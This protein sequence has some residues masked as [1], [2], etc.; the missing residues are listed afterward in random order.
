MAGKIPVI[1]RYALGIWWTRWFLWDYYS[2]RQVIETQEKNQLPVDVCILDMNWHIK[3]AWGAYS[4]DTNVFPFSN[5]TLDWLQAKNLRVAMNLHDDNG[6]QKYE[7]KFDDMCKAMGLNPDTTSQ[8]QF[9][10]CG[11][12]TYAFSLEDVVLKPLEDQ[13]INFWWID[14]QQDPTEGGCQNDDLNPTM[15]L[16][17]LRSTDSKRRAVAKS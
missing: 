17:K 7:D 2:L 1:P 9:Q 15:M 10:I 11:N 12:K 5:E 14:W 8:I 6:V 3:N 13:G 16:N 4:F